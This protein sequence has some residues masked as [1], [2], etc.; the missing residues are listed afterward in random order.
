MTVPAEVSVTTTSQSVAEPEVS[1]QTTAVSESG[2]NSLLRNPIFLVGLVI[3]VLLLGLIV[4]VALKSKDKTKS[5][6]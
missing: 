5:A 4:L 6:K 1:S 2:A 3:V